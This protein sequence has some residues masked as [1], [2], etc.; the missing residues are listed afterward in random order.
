[1]FR[2][3]L[4][5]I[6]GSTIAYGGSHSCIS[7]INKHFSGISVNQMTIMLSRMASQYLDSPWI[8]A[9]EFPLRQALP[10]ALTLS[11]FQK[12]WHATTPITRDEL[13]PDQ[14]L[15]ETEDIFQ[16][17]LPVGIDTAERSCLVCK[18]SF[19]LDKMFKVM[20][21][22]DD[23]LVTFRCQSCEDCQT[24]KSSPVLQSTSIRERA[25]QS[26]I[27]D[28]VRISLEEK[29]TYIKLPFL[30]EPVAFF[31]KHFGGEKSNY[32]QAERVYKQVCKLPENDKEGVRKAFDELLEADFFGDLDSAPPD[33]K[34]IVEDSSVLQFYLWRPVCKQS[35]TTPVR[36]VVDPTSSHLNLNVAKGSAG[37]A[38]MHSILLRARSAKH[39]W[40]SDVRKLYNCLHLEKEAIPFSLFLYSP[41]LDPNTKPKVF[42][43]KRAWYGVR[44]TGPQAS[45]AFRR[46]A[47]LHKDSHPLG[48][49]VLLEN[50][51]ADD[52]LSGTRCYLLSEQEVKE[53]KEILEAGGFSLKFVAHSFQE[54]PSDSTTDTDSLNI[55]GYKWHPVVDTVS[56]NL[57]EIN[58]QKKRRGLKPGNPE[59]VD[60]PEDIEKLV[61]SLSGL[62]RR[63]VVGKCGEIYDPIGLY[64]PVKSALKRSL[65]T[66]NHLDWNEKLSEKDKSTW[67]EYLKLWPELSKVTFS[68]STVPQDAVLP[69][70]PRIIC[71]SDASADCGGVCLYLSFLLTDQSWSSQI[72]AAKSRLLKFSVPRNELEMVELAME[73][74]FATVVSIDLPFENIIIATDSLVALCWSLNDKIRHKVYVMNR[75]LAINRFFRWIRE[76]V[77]PTCSVELVHIPG[78]EN[79]ADILTKGPPSVSMIS[80][81]S[82][83]QQGHSW[84]KKDV[85]EMPLTRFSDISLNSDEVKHYLEEVIPGDPNLRLDPVYSPVFSYFVSNDVREGHAYILRPPCASPTSFLTLSGKKLQKPKVQSVYLIDVLHIG[86]QKSCRLLSECIRF[87]VLLLHR[88][89]SNTKN[90]KVKRSLASKCPLCILI[91]SAHRLEDSV[92]NFQFSASNQHISVIPVKKPIVSTDS[93]TS[94]HHRFVC[95]DDYLKDSLEVGCE[96]GPASTPPCR[97]DVSTQLDSVTPVVNLYSALTQQCLS[98]CIDVILQA[99]WN[100][101]ATKECLAQLSNSELKHFEFDKDSKLLFYKG[102]VGRDQSISIFDLDMLELQFLDSKE[103]HFHSPCLMPNSDIFYAYAIYCHFELAHHSSPESTLHEISKRF[104]VIRPRKTLNAIL[105]DCIKCKL[106]K[107]QTLAHEMAN[108]SAVR[109]TYAPPFS[110]IQIDL[111]QHFHA[112][113]RSA[114][115]QTCKAPAFVACCLVTGAIAIHIMEDWST[116]SVVSALT[117]LGTRYGMPSIV[118]VDSGSQLK[119]LKNVTFDIQDLSHTLKCKVSCQVIVAPPKS[120]V[121]QGRIERRIGILREMLLR[122]GEPKFLM[123]F[124]AWETLFSSISNYL[125]DL[126]IARSSERSVT[127]PEY[128]ILTANR[129]LVGRNNNRALTG[130]MHI[131]LRPSSIYRRAIDAQETFFMLLH[132]HLYSLV[133][134]SKW[135]SSDH[136]QLDDIVVFFFD[137]SPLKVRSRPWHFGRVIAIDGSRL[138]LEYTIGM[139]NVKKCIERSKRDCCRI[140]AEDEL[141]FNTHDHLN[142]VLSQ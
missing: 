105:K 80:S 109:F 110:F 19:P 4:T 18:A 72:L 78:T 10:K 104:H 43:M 114:G 119:A 124:I 25:E 23:H 108:H 37:L 39:L 30:Q 53:V 76:K 28:S 45:E 81:S 96:V 42:Y 91:L 139:S 88:T 142:K 79:I 27:T 99:Y 3:Q 21:P 48:A 83:W 17:V 122:L 136:I 93:I 138:T 85:T 115:R 71:M 102:R 129:L 98:K 123:S 14:P 32:K 117:R 59:P 61:K 87:L 49:R 75:V 121:G 52:I 29:K 130:P 134:K 26:L 101:L 100:E 1:M 89:H 86:W 15:A 11:K 6:S 94:D 31:K 7:H 140:A 38:N 111:A 74:I 137:D 9:R 116:E 60:T 36:L 112:K 64:E 65:S 95:Q 70:R 41:D 92:T 141:I 13:L 12:N 107:K 69:L 35:K 73:L 84:M 125:N 8:D 97:E 133:P 56:L 16:D 127:R 132:K 106:I 128:S 22:E 57:Q 131:D 90:L 40:S 67:T 47:M 68:R 118:Y 103:I 77:G 51:Y 34:K 5:D 66:L 24:C 135:F 54:P 62:T 120:H 113:S 50:T 82:L 63:H 44:S 20:D 46:L 33:I 58:F 126:P 55:L 2:C